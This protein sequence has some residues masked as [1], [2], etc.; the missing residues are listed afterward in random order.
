MSEWTFMDF[1]SKDNLL[2]T[3]RG[4]SDEML[5]LASDPDVWEEPTAAGHWQVRDIVGHLVD[6]T[7]GYFAGFDVANGNG[8][9]PEALGVRGMNEHV[10]QGA[11][12]LR[13]VPQDELLTRLDK[14]RAEMLAI[15]EGLDADAWGGLLSERG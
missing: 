4:Q 10:D 6:T 1:A 14:D 2:R 13:G 9:A 12:A 5:A 7:E 11:L 15:I 3:V 8:T